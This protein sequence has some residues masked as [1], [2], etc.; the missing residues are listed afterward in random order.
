MKLLWMITMAFLLMGCANLR[1]EPIPVEDVIVEDGVY[2]NSDK[3]FRY[4]ERTVF[5]DIEAMITTEVTQEDFWAI[6]SEAD[7]PGKPERCVKRM[8]TEDDRTREIGWFYVEKG[9]KFQKICTDADCRGDDEMPCDHLV[10]DPA[11]GSFQEMLRYGDSVYFIAPYAVPGNRNIFN[12]MILRWQD[13]A[14]HFEKVFEAQRYLSDIH[15]SNG[16]L[17]VNAARNLGTEDTVYC[18]LNLDYLV[19][20]TVVTEYMDAEYLFGENHIIMYERGGI[21]AVNSVLKKGNLLLN[22]NKRGHIEGDY[23]WYKD[24]E[25]NGYYTLYRMDLRHPGEKVKVMED[26]RGFAVC[27]E[28]LFWQPSVESGNQMIFS[29]RNYEVV[30][31]EKIYDEGLTGYGGHD[32]LKIMRARI[33]EDMTLGT[34]KTVA[35]AGQNE[36]IGSEREWLIIGDKLLYKTVSPGNQED[37]KWYEHTYIADWQKTRKLSERAVR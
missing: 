9:L 7:S 3:V 28:T 4:G 11:A 36:W 16:L 24:Y 34:P 26:I 5:E 31:G 14:D 6:Y 30:K 23:F 20:T 32:G 1:E 17:Y 21:F 35:E 27:G 8:M 25:S 12:Y 37:I 13:G 10:L 29:Y 33:F 15:I 18:I 22:G 2:K 19:Y